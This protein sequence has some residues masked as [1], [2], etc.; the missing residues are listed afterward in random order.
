GLLW[1]DDRTSRWLQTEQQRHGVRIDAVYRN[2]S[3]P[4]R[5]REMIL[6]RVA[7]GTPYSA[8]TDVVS[9]S[10]RTVLQEASSVA[11]ETKLLSSEPIGTRHVAAAYFF[12]NPPGHDRQFH[13]E[14]GF[15]TDTWRRAFAEFIQREYATEAT[16]WAQL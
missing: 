10:A 14:W 2:R 13:I 5:S 8:R 15:E 6:E 3:H 4:E 16:Q 12:H 1:S 11:R 9:V 7:S